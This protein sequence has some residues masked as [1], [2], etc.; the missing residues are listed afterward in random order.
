MSTILLAG[1]YRFDYLDYES[2]STWALVGVWIIPDW[3]L[4]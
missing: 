3:S 2:S 1:Y 4:T